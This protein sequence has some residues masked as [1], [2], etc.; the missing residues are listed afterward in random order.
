ME[1][2]VQTHL[3]QSKIS[4]LNM[5]ISL[6][7]IERYL[8][9]LRQYPHQKYPIKNREILYNPHILALDE[10][11]ENHHIQNLN[12]A[13]FQ[14]A[15]LY[16]ETSEYL[17]AIDLLSA[18][19]SSDFE[20]EKKE[21]NSPQMRIQ[22][23]EMLAYCYYFLAK[24]EKDEAHLLKAKDCF[25]QCLKLQAIHH[26]STD[27]QIQI[28][29]GKAKLEFYLGDQAQAQDL[30]H[31]AFEMKKKW[32]WVDLELLMLYLEI[33][34]FMQKEMDA[35]FNLYTKIKGIIQQIVPNEKLFKEY[36]AE[37]IFQI[38][39]WMLKQNFMG[40]SDLIYQDA[41]KMAPTHQT[42]QKVA[43]R[44]GWKHLQTHLLMSA[45]QEEGED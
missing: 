43:S 25:D 8:K 4:V 17:K 39:N 21:K 36:F 6:S 44:R 2:L 33:Q 10:K 19:L 16:F 42:L 28:Y 9:D 22:I 31:Q 32:H 29:M 18:L 41:I 20:K 11:D 5:G 35:K 38:G 27:E 37:R 3:S 1:N 34:L 15:M 45:Q 14:Q 7:E 13:H 12:Q 26:A 23:N 30:I 24:S 40:F